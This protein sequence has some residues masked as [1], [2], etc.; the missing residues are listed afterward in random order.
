[1]IIQLNSTSFYTYT[2]NQ[3]DLFINCHGSKQEKIRIDGFNIISLT[4]GCR[5]SLNQHVFTSGVEIEENI[6]LK[7][8][9]L[10]LHLRD[11]INVQ[12]FEEREFL[13]LIE[14]EQDKTRKPIDIVDVSKK[15]HLKQ[16]SKKSK[17]NTI[18]GTSSTI[19]TLIILLIGAIILHRFCRKKYR[20]AQNNVSHFNRISERVI[21]HENPVS[22]RQIVTGENAIRNL[23][24]ET[25]DDTTITDVVEK[26]T[27]I[28]ISEI[29]R[30]VD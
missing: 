5:S 7:Q 15:F 17:L 30:N 8:N 23:Q 10:N 1:M 4:P 2:P 20:R 3:T 28:N 27:A 18:F 26:G 25:S 16:L 22:S 21:F 29:I 19:V 6:I 9:N 24:S 14:E 11:L 13:K 12:D